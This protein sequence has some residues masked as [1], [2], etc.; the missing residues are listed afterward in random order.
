MH[1]NNR[2]IPP[3]IS[4]GGLIWRLQRSLPLPAHGRPALLI[5]LR[6]H[7]ALKQRSPRLTVINIFDAGGASGLMCQFIVEDMIESR[8]IFVAPI[9]Q[10]SFERG[11]PIRQQIAAYQRHRVSG[12]ATQ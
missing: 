1:C 7:K 2:M 8:R 6:A 9:S 3:A 4:D 11:H 10:F 12:C 5:F